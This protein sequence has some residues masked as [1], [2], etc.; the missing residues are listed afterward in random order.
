M[1]QE[2]MNEKDKKIC[3]M[4]TGSF[5]KNIKIWNIEESAND[6]RYGNNLMKDLCDIHS[7]WINVINII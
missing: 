2:Y 6:S 7:D 3:V 4:I 5:D 1:E